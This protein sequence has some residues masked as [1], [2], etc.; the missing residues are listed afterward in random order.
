MRLDTRAFAKAAGVIAGAGMFLLTL[1]LVAVG[2]PEAHS[3]LSAAMFGYSVS[4]AGAF[5]GAAWAFVYAFVLGA[6]FAFVYNIAIV[7]P[8]PPPFEWSPET[9]PKDS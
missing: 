4:A 9:Q 1:L 6:A 8:A 2:P 5:I 3:V 7:P